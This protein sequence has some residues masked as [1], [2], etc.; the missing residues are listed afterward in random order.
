MNDNTADILIC[1]VQLAGDMRNTVH[2][3]VDNPVTYPEL[4]ILQTIHGKD[5]VLNV[6]VVDTITRDPDVERAR[7]TGVYGG[8]VLERLFPGALAPLPLMSR[9]AI[10]FETSPRGVKKGSKAAIAMGKEIARSMADAA[11]GRKDEEPIIVDDDEEIPAETP[12]EKTKKAK[13][14]PEQLSIADTLVGKG[15]L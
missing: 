7:L 6:R 10:P 13:A 8:D 15:G 1:D 5:H 14:P 11:L 9:A 4:L 2:R 12:V 3:G